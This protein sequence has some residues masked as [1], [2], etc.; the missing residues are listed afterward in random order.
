MANIKIKT[1]KRV[2]PM[3]YAYTTPDIIYHE[4]WTK[5]GYTERDV[6]TRIREQTQTANIKF[7]KEWQ[8]YAVFANGNWFKDFEFHSYLAKNKVERKINETSNNEGYSEWF[9]ISGSESKRMFDEF[10]NNKGI[11][12]TN[13]LFEY[14]L[15]NEQNDAVIQT[16]N[17]F[18]TNNNREFLWNAKPRFG[19]TISAYELCKRLDLIKILIVTNRPSIANSWYED[20]VKFLGTDNYWFVSDTDALKDKEYVVS[21]ENYLK[22]I[23]SE[24]E[25]KLIQFVSLQDLK[26]SI[27]FGGK[28]NKLKYIYDTKWDLLII[29]EA[30][31]GVDTYKTDTALN[32]VRRIY[33][34]H[35]SGTPF[36]AIANEKFEA[37][38]IYNWTYFDEQNAKR[39]WD[40]A[41]ELENPY[42]DL[43]QLNMYTYKMSDI[44]RE[45]VK[46]GADFDDDGENED[47]CFNLNEFFKTNAAGEFVHNEAIDK[48]LDVLVTGDKFPFSTAELRN[49][50]R[51]TLWILEYVDSAKALEKKL[52]E[53]PV[54]KDYKIVRAAGE[55]T[56]DNEDNQNINKRIKTNYD[57][58]KKAIAE[59][60][61]TITISVG[62]LTVGVTFPEWTAVLMLSNMK[63]SAQ[64]MQAAFRAQNPCLFQYEEN[65]EIKNLRKENA[66]VFDFDPTRTL[67]L[68]D[69]FAND[70]NS[71]KTNEKFDLETRKT[72]IRKLL[73]FFPVYAEDESG[74]MFLL[75]AEKVLSIPI[76]IQSK[77]VVDRGFMSNFLFEDI[78]IIFKAPQE[79]RDIIE[80]M[81]PIKTD[82]KKF[83]SAK[84]QL[85]FD[86]QENASLPNEKDIGLE[87]DVFGK[88][89]YKTIKGDLNNLTSYDDWNQNKN[90]IC[91]K[92]QTSFI[93]ELKEKYKNQISESTYKKI[94]KKFNKQIEDFVNSQDFQFQ[95]NFDELQSQMKTELEKFDG[96]EEK[97]AAIKQT[98]ENKIAAN[99]QNFINEIQQK[100]PDF[101]QE[102]N[103]SIINSVEEEIKEKPKK[104]YLEEMRNHLRGFSRTIP[105]FLM[106]YGNENTTIDNFDQIVP[107]DVFLEIT[108]IS[109]DQFKKLKNGF[110]YEDK[111]SN[112]IKH[113]DCVFNKT[114]FNQSIKEFLDRKKKLSNYF[115]N[116]SD[117]DIFDFVPSQKTN[118]I[119]TPKSVVIKMV[120]LLEQKN[121]KCFSNPNHTF[122][123]LYM[124]SGL[125][126]TEIVKRLFRNQKMKTI[127]PDD[128]TRLNHIFKNQVFGL[129]PT[130][131]IF[132]IVKS[133]ILGFTKDYE[134]RN[135][136]IK[137]YDLTEHLNENNIEDSISKLFENKELAN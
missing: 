30:H 124:K 121:P 24:K 90:L 112:T 130:E 103:N 31:E 133:Y 66:Y 54:F 73:N 13:A 58:V 22:H 100:I 89:I 52:N 2:F 70:L 64:Y 137:H 107:D 53:H 111:E 116:D 29:D 32:S 49:E 79:V 46:K 50:L 57:K 122:I 56:N 61:K 110:D 48:F 117:T 77:E 119:F 25:K 126:I 45:K 60:D 47:F 12:E 27:Y 8:D 62:Q 83:D 20:Y 93:E 128:K 15:R 9:K 81:N 35:L 33:T 21:R 11:L 120:D 69:N 96:D 87:K 28:H 5:I 134:I 71:I 18:K 38:A 44:I 80:R 43:P 75:D 59:N 78:G 88:E 4:G 109:L 6:D 51:H 74:E 72:N 37:N 127:F 86:N 14:H 65:G 135:F 102:C 19:K 17:Y 40:N 23:G 95:N 136:N 123:D 55:L 99:N 7:K 85:F 76:T 114:V 39:N 94:T 98:Y 42:Q 26:G 106:A 101:I 125:Y 84:K 97:V 131:I 132:K 113:Y 63:S 34:L 68:F 36:K 82:L 3:I 105:L 16:I 41:N 129:A 92:A 104:D 10:R 91:Q 67:V 1:S 115:E 108:G 118:Q